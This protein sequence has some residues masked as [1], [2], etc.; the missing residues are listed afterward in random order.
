MMSNNK[1]LTAKRLLAHGLALEGGLAS[2]GNQGF[3]SF[4]TVFNAVEE[5]YT[6]STS[7]STAMKEVYYSPDALLHF[8][9]I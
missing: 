1:P 4:W 9:C 2:P 8:M 7:S 5:L 6:E 3:S